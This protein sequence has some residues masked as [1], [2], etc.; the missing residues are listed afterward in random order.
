MALLHR[1][2]IR[3]DQFGNIHMEPVEKDRTV[4]LARALVDQ[5]YTFIEGVLVPEQ[6]RSFVVIDS[7]P[8][9][10]LAECL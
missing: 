10:G 2:F 6:N 7:L 8:V 5:G 1:L 9:A 4:L 3:R